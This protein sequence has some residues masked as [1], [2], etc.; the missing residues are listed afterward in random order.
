MDKPFQVERKRARNRVAASKCRMRKLEKIAVLDQQANQL[1]SENENL[2][3]LAEKLRS[4][5]YGLKQELRWHL[6]NGCR[7]AQSQNLDHLDHENHQ[8]LV[9][10]TMDKLDKSTE[11]TNSHYEQHSQNFHQN[12]NSKVDFFK[13]YIE[14]FRDYCFESSYCDKFLS[15]H[16]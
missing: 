10:P 9:P 3:K 4:Q 12:S 16:S 11:T 2:A 7:I 5:V 14:G 6:N 1:R 13:R 8:S 15:K